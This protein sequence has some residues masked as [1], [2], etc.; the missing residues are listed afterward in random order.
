MS[1]RLFERD[2]IAIVPLL[3]VDRWL[4]EILQIRLCGRFVSRTELV[5]DGLEVVQSRYE[6][7]GEEG[8]RDREVVN[9]PRAEG[10][11]SK[12]PGNVVARENANRITGDGDPLV[13]NHPCPRLRKPVISVSTD[14]PID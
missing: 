11:L 8:W 1:V 13:R 9:P 4:Y 14:R 12:V 3:R 10:W 7:G 2:R 6:Q 5:A